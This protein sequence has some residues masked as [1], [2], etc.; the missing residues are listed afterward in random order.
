MNPFDVQGA[1]I[2]HL[3][4]LN[5]LKLVSVVFS[6]NKSLHAYWKAADDEQVNRSLFNTAVA[7][8]ADKAFWAVSQAGRIGNPAV[9]HASGCRP[10]RSADGRQPAFRHR[11]GNPFQ[12]IR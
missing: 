7:L 1:L 5:I 6:G 11:A 12:S 9:N 8:G 4:S 2:R 3:Q 10:I